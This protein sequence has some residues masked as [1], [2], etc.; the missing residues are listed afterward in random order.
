[1]VKVTGCQPST[2]TMALVMDPAQWLAEHKPGAP[3]PP[4]V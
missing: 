1:M 2:V 4:E 3:F